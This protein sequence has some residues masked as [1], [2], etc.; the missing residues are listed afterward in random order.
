MFIIVLAAL[1]GLAIHHDLT[2]LTTP[3]DEHTIV[4][5]TSGLD[6]DRSTIL[7]GAAARFIRTDAWSLLFRALVVAIITTLL[8]PG[9]GRKG[10]DANQGCDGKNETGGGAGHGVRSRRYRLNRG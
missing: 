4:S 7:A 8:R 9:T 2:D 1:A 5:I 3:L 10:S 6:I